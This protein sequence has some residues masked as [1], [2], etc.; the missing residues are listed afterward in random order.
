MLLVRVS[1]KGERAELDVSFFVGG[2]IK[3]IFK[4]LDRVSPL[5]FKNQVLLNQRE[6]SRAGSTGKRTR[7]STLVIAADCLFLV[8]EDNISRL[9]DAEEDLRVKV[10]PLSSVFYGPV[11]FILG[12]MATGTTFQWVYLGKDREMKRLAPILDL[13]L[14]C[15][16]ELLLSICS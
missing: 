12:Y 13:S 6:T 14:L 7:R 3:S 4:M 2:N 5:S 10:R 16:L 11:M 9:S 15:A 8:G 1:N